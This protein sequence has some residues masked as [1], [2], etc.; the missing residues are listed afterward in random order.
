MPRPGSHDWCGS[1]GDASFMSFREGTCPLAV[2][3]QEPPAFKQRLL[4]SPPLPGQVCVLP[5]QPGQEQNGA[6]GGLGLG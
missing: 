6:G 2:G 5:G 3:A 1:H 4:D